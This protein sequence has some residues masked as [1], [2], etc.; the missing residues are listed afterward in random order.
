MLDK[1]IPYKNVIMRA[2]TYN[3]DQENHLPAGFHLKQFEN[4]DEQQWA[5]IETSVGEFTSTSEALEY[6]RKHYMSELSVLR[7]RC[8]FALD[9]FGRHA[10]TC[11]AW[12]DRRGEETVGSL[13]WL[14]VKP[15]FQGQGIAKA[16][17]SRTMCLFKTFDSYPVYL[18]TQTWSYKA[19]MLYHSFGFRILK[20][21]S[22]A[23]YK[24]DFDEAVPIL[25]NVLNDNRYSRLKS[26]VI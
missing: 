20:S 22:F 26:S 21:E 16:L 3:P 13:H 17:L 5:E 6:F 24:N 12:Y 9:L 23:Q 10:G 4:G 11:T 8:Y 18:H 2:D 19:I 7:S 14:A 25:E 1:T 15:E